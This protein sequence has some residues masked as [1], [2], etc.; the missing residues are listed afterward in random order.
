MA[1]KKTILSSIILIVGLGS[2][3]SIAEVPHVFE[4]GKPALAGEMNENFTAIDTSPPTLIASTTLRDDLLYI[5]SISITDDVELD[6]FV[7]H[8]GNF[9]KIPG[10]VN[11]HDGSILAAPRYGENLKSVVISAKEF[12]FGPGTK[13][14]A[15]DL[16]LIHI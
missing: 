5:H 6:K 3:A 16:S 9:V 13:E 8:N 1:I 15:L 14:V 12:S 10:S 11:T 2:V 4:S 7:T